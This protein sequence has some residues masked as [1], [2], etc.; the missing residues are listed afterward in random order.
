M[1]KIFNRFHINVQSAYFR[2]LMSTLAV[3]LIPLFLIS[4]LISSQTVKTLEQQSEI[5]DSA[6]VARTQESVEQTI[7]IVQQDAATLADSR[8]ILSFVFLPTFT[9]HMLLQRVGQDLHDVCTSNPLI[10]SAYV[11][12]AYHQKIMTSMHQRGNG[13]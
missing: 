13:Y 10:S 2:I 7:S 6:F 8:D 4:V 3:T 1:S 11:Y 12:S 5:I 9:D